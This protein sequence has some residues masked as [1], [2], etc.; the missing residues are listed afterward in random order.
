MDAIVGQ[1]INLSH[2]KALT[3]GTGLTDEGLTQLKNMLSLQELTIGPSHITG[4]GIAALSELSSLKALCLHQMKLT[5]EDEWAAFGKLSSLQCLTL[6]HIRSEVTDA[7]IAHLSGL[8][9]LRDLSIDAVIIRDQNA[10]ASLDIT[11]K[12]LTHLA[13]LKS[14]ENLRLTGAKITDEGLQQL[15]E[16]PTLRWLDLQGCKVTE[17]GLQR[18]KKKLPA[19][20]WY[21]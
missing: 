6:M 21:L 2:L 1:L 5:S 12:G 18:L 19:L 17:Q 16:I 8:Q 3:L 11:D 9:S 10:I 4:K 7:H 13:K 14:L 15:S 20:Q